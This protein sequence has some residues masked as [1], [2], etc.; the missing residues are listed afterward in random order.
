MKGFNRIG[1]LGL[2]LLG[3]G[4]IP[5]PLT[6][7][8]DPAEYERL[9]ADLQAAGISTTDVFEVGHM[10]PAHFVS[11]ARTILDM[12]RALLAR[13]ET[14]IDA[15]ELWQRGEALRTAGDLYVRE[16]EQE[17]LRIRAGGHPLD[18]SM[19]K[20]KQ[21]L[22]AAAREQRDRWFAGVFGSRRAPPVKMICDA[23]AMK[24]RAGAPHPEGPCAL[25]FDG[26]CK[27]CRERTHAMKRA[28][29]PSAAERRARKKARRS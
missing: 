29:R 11:V 18:L 5:P 13:G 4:V 9:M 14:V 20:Q 12:H 22:S 28:S 3:L 1:G 2:A 16:A 6:S 23:C 24:L 21:A 8:P 10:D 7:A 25:G 27:V 15:R 26:Q 19:S 17:R